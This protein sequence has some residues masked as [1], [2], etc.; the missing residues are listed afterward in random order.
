ML[1]TRATLK[2]WTDY[3]STGS[4]S[5]P[6]DPWID[7]NV[8]HYYTALQS[9][10]EKSARD[11]EDTNAEYFSNTDKVCFIFGMYYDFLME[12]SHKMQIVMEKISAFRKDIAL[13][14]N[15]AMKILWTGLYP[16]EE[17]VSALSPFD[18]KIL[19]PKILSDTDTS[20]DE[21]DRDAGSNTAE[22]VATNGQTLDGRV[23]KNAAASALL[24]SINNITG[25]DRSKHDMAKLP[26]FEIVHTT[27]I[28]INSFCFDE[29][30]PASAYVTVAT[31]NGIIET[32][33]K[34]SLKFRKR[35]KNK[36]VL[37][38]RDD[39]SWQK[40]RD[41][42][43][44]EENNLLEQ[45]MLDL[46]SKESLNMPTLAKLLDRGRF[47][48]SC[49]DNF[50][51]NKS[52]IEEKTLEAMEAMNAGRSFTVDDLQASCMESHTRFPF[53]M[54]GNA[55]GEL[56]LWSFGQTNCLAMYA[57]PGDR[58]NAINNVHFN[59]L[60]D[61]FVACNASGVVQLWKFGSNPNC[62]IPYEI[63]NTRLNCAK[64][65]LFLNSGSVIA[66]G[67]SSDPSEKSIDGSFQLWD[68][69]L[70]KSQQKLCSFGQ[71]LDAGSCNALMYLPMEELLVCGYESGKLVAFDIRQRCMLEVDAFNRRNC[72]RSSIINISHSH[73]H[74]LFGTASSDGCIK[75]W[76]ST[77]LNLKCTYQNVHDEVTKLSFR[78]DFL[79]SSGSDGRM[80]FLDVKKELS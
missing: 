30:D 8:S 31:G 65:A 4:K 3:I 80:V 66:V 72:H 68:T 28:A 22:D 18:G 36:K 76:D 49:Q 37:L 16:E 7:T 17:V 43:W 53:Y 77:T 6:T 1:Q 62:L 63:I 56:S 35:S 9:A 34:S 5:H 33:I 58:S 75:I 38:D 51:P 42:F 13:S 52:E 70:P 24:N 71:K 21:D 64:D 20:A 32:N 59:G 55:L 79:Y 67:G 78:G 19:S 10:L 50:V 41:R 26:F 25:N 11:C 60:G 73:E 44:Q 45:E 54:C 39:L 14:E 69:L 23:S 27:N 46:A 57:K 47:T 15:V 2:L 29:S 12:N 48:V 40:S 74:N 61:K